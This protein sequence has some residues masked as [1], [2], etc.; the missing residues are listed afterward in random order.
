M[1]LT[2]S[3]RYVGPGL[4][5]TKSEFQKVATMRRSRQS[6]HTF[7]NLDID[8]IGNSADYQHLLSNRKY[9]KGELEHMINLRTYKPTTK[10][11]PEEPWCMP[12]AKSFSPKDQYVD[13]NREV[14]QKL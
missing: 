5:P 13:E 2:D 1:K 7:A 11:L 9:S 6:N 12:P 4:H 3:H 10:F 14:G 8:L